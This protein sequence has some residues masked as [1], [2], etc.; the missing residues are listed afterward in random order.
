MDTNLP[1]LN[2]NSLIPNTNKAEQSTLLDYNADNFELTVVAPVFNEEESLPKLFSA[3][4]AYRAKASTSVCFLLVNDG[5]SDRSLS[6]IE[7]YCKNNQAFFY[8]SLEQRCGLTGALKAG[9]HN[10]RTK[11]V[12]YIDADL[13]T[14]PDDFELLLAFKDEADLIC[15]IRRKRQDSLSKKIQ[16]KLA[17]KIRNAITHDGFTDTNCP[18]KILKTT[19]AQQLPLF[20]GMHRFLP[21][22][23]LLMGY[24]VKAISV[25]HQERKQGKSKF[26]FFN[27][28]FSGAFDLLV[29]IWM[30]KRYIN[31]K[32]GKNNIN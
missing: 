24:K 13:Q 32:V 9:F 30:R 22:L 28:A 8:I 29:F 1:P 12:G 21:A 26:N 27:R 3:L 10:C 31:P 14:F 7:E 16:S 6:L 15:G 2:Q 20:S 19:L 18:L 25:R 4:S 11:W 23:S 17:N 5:S